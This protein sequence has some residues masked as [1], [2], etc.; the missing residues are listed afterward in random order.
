MAILFKIVDRAEWARAGISGVYEG[1]ADDRRDGFIHLSSVSQVAE[2][3]AKHFVGRMGLAL[4]AF[5][6]D[7]L[8]RLKWEASR[9]GA[10]FPHVYGVIPVGLALWVKELPLQG[11]KHR[12]PEGI[13][14]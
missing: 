4:V 9:G 5:D 14:A 6:E 3:A 13:G 1:S 10:L 11:E 12:F 2:T 7:D 8:E